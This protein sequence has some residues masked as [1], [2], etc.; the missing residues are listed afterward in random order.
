M[1][2]EYWSRCRGT[3]GECDRI[4]TFAHGFLR[5]FDLTSRSTGDLAGSG[6]DAVHLN[7]DLRGTLR[8]HFEDGAVRIRRSQVQKQRSVC[9]CST[10]TTGRCAFCVAPSGAEM[11]LGL[12]IWPEQRVVSPGE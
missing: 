2:C 7:G 1:K 11:W 6:Q 10:A 4:D 3:G 12:E 8:V 5:E 9:L